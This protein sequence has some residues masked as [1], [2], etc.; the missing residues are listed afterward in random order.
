MRLGGFGSG[1]IEC[2][3]PFHTSVLDHVVTTAEEHDVL[4]R[5]VVGV[6]VTVMALRFLGA[7][8]LAGAEV[9]PALCSLSSIFTAR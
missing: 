6:T 7:A 5:V 2:Q 4:V 9:I 3:Q 8:N 1:G